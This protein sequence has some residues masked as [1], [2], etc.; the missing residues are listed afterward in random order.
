MFKVTEKAAE[1]IFK[2]AK[3]NGMAGMA[4][5]IAAR[6]QPDGSI[7]YGVGFDDKRDDD[8]HINSHG[9]DIIFESSYKDLL[10]GAVM[11]FVELEQEKFHFIFLNP[12]D[13][14]YVPPQGY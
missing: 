13:A 2:S 7:E 12:N 1:Q 11:D 9:I 3:E 5:R 8:V 14:H 10:Q 6:R 4:L